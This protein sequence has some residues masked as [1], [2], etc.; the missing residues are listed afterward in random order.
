MQMNEVGGLFSV[1]GRQSTPGR[2]VV[3]PPPECRFKAHR[4]RTP[5]KA[6]R[7]QIGQ[8]TPAGSSQSAHR[9]L[10]N[11]CDPPIRS[12]HFPFPLRLPACVGSPVCHPFPLLPREL[13]R[14]P[15]VAIPTSASLHGPFLHLHCYPSYSVLR[16]FFLTEPR[17]TQRKNCRNSHLGV[18]V[19]P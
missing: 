19:S 17:R 4:K 18:F 13:S 16:G 10:P 9:E 15:S 1:A 12:P 3:P 8:T 2:S 7:S 6:L 5:A 11:R 14:T